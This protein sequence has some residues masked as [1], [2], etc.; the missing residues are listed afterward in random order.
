LETPNVM[1]RNQSASQLSNFAESAMA[2]NRVV[3]QHFSMMKHHSGDSESSDC[4]SSSSLFGLSPPS[5]SE[6]IQ[7]RIR[8]SITLI[9]N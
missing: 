2:V 7:R 8:S 3:L 4:G 1:R 5:E 9:C 6:L